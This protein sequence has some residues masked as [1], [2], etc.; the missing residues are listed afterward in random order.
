MREFV[1]GATLRKC[2]QNSGI[3]YGHTAVDYANFLRDIFMEYVWNNMRNEKLSGRVEIDESLFGRKRKYNKGQ[4]K[5]TEIWI[6]GTI[7]F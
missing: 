1:L 4:K 6:F 5:G 2:C 7:K 3:A